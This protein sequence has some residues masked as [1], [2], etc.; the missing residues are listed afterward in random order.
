MGDNFQ[1]RESSQKL[2]RPLCKIA[3]VKLHCLPFVR[4]Y[5]SKLQKQT[6]STRLYMH[7]LTLSVTS[8][9]R[10]GDRHNGL[11]AQKKHFSSFLFSVLFQQKLR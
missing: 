5:G 2:I 8:S 3:L 7:N 1:T 4:P 10:L 9:G 6:I 11:G